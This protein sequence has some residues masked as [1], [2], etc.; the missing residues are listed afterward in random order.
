[1]VTFIFQMQ[2][3]R[4]IKAYFVLFLFVAFSVQNGIALYLHNYFHEEKQSLPVSN[5]TSQIKINCSCF[6][7]FCLPFTETSQQKIN[8]LPVTYGVY[9][10]FY[11]ACII[12][13]P[14][15]HLSLRAP[16]YAS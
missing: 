9:N 6:S 2:L 3:E 15:L 14:S 4:I 8:L 13:I 7:D 10:C 5:S 1:M 12:L 16:P 11:T